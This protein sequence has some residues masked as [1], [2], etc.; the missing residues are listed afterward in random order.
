[1]NKTAKT[2]A[3]LHG[4]TFTLFFIVNTVMDYYVYPLLYG[5]LDSEFLKIF[6]DTVMAAVLYSVLYFI[7]RTV[8]IVAVFKIKRKNINLKGTWYHVHIK[9]DLYD[10]I[11]TD[12]LRAGVTT[13]KQDFYDVRF[14]ADNSYFSL[15]ENGNLVEDVNA[16]HQ[17]HWEHLTCSFDGEGKIIACYKADSSRK[18]IAQCCPLCHSPLP[19]G[20]KAAAEKTKRIGIHDL[21]VISDKKIKGT[22]A[23]EY[24]SA[25]Y[26]EIF[27]FRNK[28]ERDALIKDFLQDGDI[29]EAV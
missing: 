23:D 26:G 29:D 11:K 3:W 7:V 5:T 14:T 19:E 20:K 8:Y 15:D 9:R 13:V 2:V 10:F 24:P 4:I 21:T 16:A 1:M 12:K 22:F 18:Q 25:S 27:F 6:I 17:T 28:E